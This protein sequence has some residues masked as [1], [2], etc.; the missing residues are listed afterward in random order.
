[1]LINAIRRKFKSSGEKAI[2]ILIIIFGTVAGAI[3]YFIVIKHF[4]P[5]SL[6]KKK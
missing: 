6:P 2:W 3:I 5:K 1:M 4:N